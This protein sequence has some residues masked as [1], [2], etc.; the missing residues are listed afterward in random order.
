MGRTDVYAVER[1]GRIGVFWNKAKHVI[2]YERSVV[3]SKQ[4]M[5]EQEKNLGRPMLR[6]VKEYVEILEDVR[7]YP[8]T[9]LQSA[10]DGSG[11]VQACMFSKQIIPVSN[12]WASNVSSLDG[13]VDLGWQIP[14]WR[15]GSDPAIYPK[16]KIEIEL[17]SP[18][19]DDDAI[20]IV[21]LTDPQRV[22][23]YTDVR[24]EVDGQRLTDD[25]HA[26][27]AVEGIDY[28][29]Q[30]DP[31]LDDIEPSISTSASAI[32]DVLPDAPATFPG[33]ERFTFSVNAGE[34]HADVAG[35][36]F[37]DA[38]LTGKLRNFMMTRSAPAQELVTPWWNGDKLAGASK[39]ARSALRSLVSNIDKDQPPLLA[40]SANGF[41]E[42]IKTLRE[43]ASPESLQTRIVG[44]VHSWVTKADNLHDKLAA[45][46]QTVVAEPKLKYLQDLWKTPPLA[47][48]LNSI[49]AQL[50]WREALEGAEA[51]ASRMGIV[52]KA[53]QNALIADLSTNLAGSVSESIALAEAR[54]TRLKA[55]L[56]AAAGFPDWQLGELRKSISESVDRIPQQGVKAVEQ[57]FDQLA[58]LVTRIQGV[59]ADVEA[60]VRELLDFIANEDPAKTNVQA[61][62]AAFAKSLEDKLKALPDSELKKGGHA[63]SNRAYRKVKSNP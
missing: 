42:Q 44:D 35:S 57:L 45:L 47:E 41:L 62:L 28:P 6:K 14:L 49:P 23:F 29:N 31:H 22:Y 5:N 4:F 53:G 46:N 20:S 15:A 34:S 32:D 25:V 16:P 36:Y 30:P 61:E 24:S 10:F 18:G 59:G 19:S 27:P 21:P 56:A 9:E 8:D 60:A 48:A 11:C 52:L 51:I 58:H 37:D 3:P 2:I 50:A 13:N 17:R 43:G 26:W 54:L 40:S 7:R 12:S 33:L 63:R 55:E 38:Q 39:A 1:I